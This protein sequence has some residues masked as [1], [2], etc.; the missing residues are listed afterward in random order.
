[1]S[2]ERGRS[3]TLFILFF[4]VAQSVCSA[5]WYSSSKLT[6]ERRYISV[7]GKREETGE[8][9]PSGPRRFL[10][11]SRPSRKSP[12]PTP[13][14][15][16]VVGR[17]SGLPFPSSPLS[18]VLSAPIPLQ[19]CLR[20]RFAA[21]RVSDGSSAVLFVYMPENHREMRHGTTGCRLFT[22]LLLKFSRELKLESCH[23]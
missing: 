2:S 11:G 22:L 13:Q 7:A 1:M 9:S 5:G 3:K 12:I 17:V 23:L 6:W 10:C 16:P 4:T 19:C 8:R 18:A 20:S 14:S 15:Q 21:A